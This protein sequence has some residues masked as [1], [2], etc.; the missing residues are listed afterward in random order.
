M[1]RLQ[2]RRPRLQGAHVEVL[3]TL[4]R[5]GAATA[6]PTA[7]AAT[8][9]ARGGAGRRET[10]AAKR[11]RD[12]SAGGEHGARRAMSSPSQE[13][14]DTA[15]PSRF[16]SL[17]PGEQLRASLPRRFFRR[18]SAALFREHFFLLPLI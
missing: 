16:I 14:Y 12:A 9:D 7:A 1:R 5:L 6:T 17:A 4:L 8:S 11:H 3:H 2:G 10:A 18:L 13:L 15:E